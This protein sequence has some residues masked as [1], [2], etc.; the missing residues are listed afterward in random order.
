MKPNDFYELSIGQSIWYKD[1]NGNVHEHF[2]TMLEGDCHLYKHRDDPDKNSKWYFYNICEM[3]SLT[4]PMEKVRA[5]AYT[6]DGVLCARFYTNKAC[7][8][9]GGCVVKSASPEYIIKNFTRT[10]FYI[11]V[12]E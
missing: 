8:T 3:L 10:E 6:D 9:Y 2:I 1:S 11:E 4:K 5:Y 7:Y 12:W